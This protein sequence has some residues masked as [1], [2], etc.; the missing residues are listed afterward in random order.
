MSLRSLP[1]IDP[2][3]TDVA[4]LSAAIA[5]IDAPPRREGVVP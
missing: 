1:A 3:N 2:G 5:E 4:E